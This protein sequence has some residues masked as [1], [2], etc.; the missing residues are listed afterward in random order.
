MKQFK[1]LV[2]LLR[3]IWI[4]NWSFCIISIPVGFERA[5]NK[6]VTVSPERGRLKASYEGSGSMENL[7]R[8]RTAEVKKFSAQQH[9]IKAVKMS[10]LKCTCVK[11]WP[12]VDQPI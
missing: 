2:S 10:Y 9:N 5:Q 8:Q 3:L 11:L 1:P 7:N 12:L 4:L 6:Q